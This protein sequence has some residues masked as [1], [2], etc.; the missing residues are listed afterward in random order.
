MAVQA[1]Q[2]YWY[3]WRCRHSVY[4]INQPIGCSATRPA[5]VGLC[6]ELANS[7]LP[8]LEERALAAGAVQANSLAETKEVCTCRPDCRRSLGRM[9]FDALLTHIGKAWL[10]RSHELYYD[11]QS[12]GVA[13]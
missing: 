10:H 11:P 8:G 13:I 12:C 3:I 1:G 4:A 5:V 2:H 7:F 9:L 6:R